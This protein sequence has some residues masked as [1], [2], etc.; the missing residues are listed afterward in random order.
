MAH[1]WFFARRG[2]RVRLRSTGP[3]LSLARYP[4]ALRT[5]VPD[6]AAAGADGLEEGAGLTPHDVTH[7][8]PRQRSPRLDREE[9]VAPTPFP[10]DEHSFDATARGA[11]ALYAGPE[12]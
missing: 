12:Q 1:S 9:T 7:R 4:A 2:D 10:S 11:D 8:R 5:Y 3:F 6:P